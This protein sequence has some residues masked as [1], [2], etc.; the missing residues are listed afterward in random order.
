MFSKEQSLL[1]LSGKPSEHEICEAIGAIKLAPKCQASVAVDDNWGGKSAYVIRFASMSPSLDTLLQANKFKPMQRRGIH[2]YARLV[3]KESYTFL[4]TQL[5]LTVLTVPDSAK[6]DKP[7][8]SSKSSKADT[9]EPMT[10]DEMPDVPN[11]MSERQ[12][13]IAKMME[14]LEDD[15]PSTSITIDNVLDFIAHTTSDNV[16]KIFAACLERSKA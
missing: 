10:T 14:M 6:A 12:R 5:G 4:T 16:L 15:T 7:S 11:T 13:M 8:K 3:G 2:A 1:G 9:T